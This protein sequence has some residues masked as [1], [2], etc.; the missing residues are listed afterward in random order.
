ML[1]EDHPQTLS[2]KLNLGKVLVGL[3]RLNES[4]VVFNQCLIKMK[5]VNGVDHPDTAAAEH[6]LKGVQLMKN[7]PRSF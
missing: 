1:G 4:E 5:E 3:G 6:C 2:T 7:F